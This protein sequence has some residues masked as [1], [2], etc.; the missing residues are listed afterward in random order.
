VV[1]IQ[2][3]DFDLATEMEAL[4]SA[5]SSGASVTF[6][7]YVRDFDKQGTPL[8][9]QHY[10]GMTEKVLEKICASA[11]QRWQLHRVRLI[12]RVGDLSVGD[13]IVFVGVS[14]SHRHEAFAACEYIIDILKTEAPFWKREGSHWV[15]AQASDTQRAERW[16][17]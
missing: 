4:T 6:V 15:E 11:L 8:T 17:K 14:A 2:H 10:P 9:L 12:H 3:S 1:V 16:L 5:G 13:K 7:G